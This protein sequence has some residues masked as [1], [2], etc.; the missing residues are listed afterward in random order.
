MKISVK[1]SQ[2][3]FEL[4]R[5]RN[6]NEDANIT[7]GDAVSFVVRSVIQALAIEKTLNPSGLKKQVSFKEAFQIEISFDGK[8]FTETTRL[9]IPK[10]STGIERTTDKLVRVIGLSM[11]NA[12]DS[13]DFDAFYPFFMDKGLLQEAKELELAGML[14]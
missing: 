11:L 2:N 3:E 4:S 12:A 13:N 8:S 7:L 6:Y 5:E 9:S 1:V 10:Q 14:N